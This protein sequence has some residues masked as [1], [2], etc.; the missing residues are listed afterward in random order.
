[1]TSVDAKAICKR[2][3][4]VLFTCPLYVGCGRIRTH[5][6]QGGSTL[7][8]IGP[9]EIIERLGAGGMGTVY[10]A[11]HTDSGQV[12]ALKVLRS[13]LAE[14]PLFLRRFQREAAIA[15]DLDAQ[16]IVRTLDAGVEGDKPYIAME[17]VEG[18]SLSSHLRL[19]GPLSPDEARDIALQIARGL[20][21]AHQRGIVHRDIS[22]HNVLITPD[23]LARIADFGIARSQ[24][25]ATLT[26]TA[27]FVGK[28]AY[29]APETIE[30]TA[31]IRSDIYSLG[32]TLFEML[33]GRP[34]FIGPTPLAVMQMHRDQ[35]PPRLS[36]LGIRVPPD[37]E[38]TLKRCLEKDPRQ[39]FQIPADLVASLSGLDDGATIMATGMTDETI[40]AD[41]PTPTLPNK[42]RGTIPALFR[43][44]PLAAAAIAL[45]GMVMA[46]SAVGA[47]AW[48]V[49]GSERRESAA[50]AGGSP[51]PATR[52]SSSNAPASVTV[53]PVPATPTRPAA[54]TAPT[55]NSP[56]LNAFLRQGAES[57]QF[58]PTFYVSPGGGPLGYS[59]FVWEVSFPR[60]NSTQS[61]SVFYIPSTWGVVPGDE[62]PVGTTTGGVARSSTLGLINAACNQEVPLEFEMLNGSLDRSQTV[63]FADLDGNNT[64]DFADDYDGDGVPNAVELYPDFLDRI[65]PGLQPL[66]RSAGISLVAGTPVLLQFL[67][68]PAGT[69]ITDSIP[70]DASLGYP[71][72]MLLQDWLDP[73]RVASPGVITDECSPDY[74]TIGNAGRSPDGIALL[75]DPPDWNDTHSFRGF[76][77]RDSDA[78]GIEN[79][80]DACPSTPNIGD[81]R[82]PG[83]GDADSDGLDAACDPSDGVTN[84]DEDSDGYLNRQ[85]NCPLT[86]NGEREDNQE[87]RDLDGIGD[88]CDVQPNT[89]DGTMTTVFLT[90]TLSKRIF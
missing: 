22:P 81:P 1:M 59:G 54:P 24:A 80:L 79:R 20:D 63:S 29:S 56:A 62:I 71:V 61:L 12:V 10:R 23:G 31:D 2:P 76:G 41:T 90:T 69:T 6:P 45:A 50:N 73:D 42:P 44:R 86:P 66:R 49:D 25:T 37:I 4:I 58:Q 21:E 51:S 77:F 83:S 8:K 47:G 57:A 18:E 64:R 3:A 15:R 36:D 53:T 60:G 33:A 72:V 74:W 9:Y 67:T 55:G 46:I 87:D 5:H 84:S 34:A 16:Y 78:D 70:G 28:P 68:Y 27:I 30:G 85:D 52:A 17:L 88:A 65:V 89:A 39:R 11:R 26:T 43:H 48:L 82:V 13:D 7:D 75:T 35:P 32:V 14:D 40:V 38:F 19:T